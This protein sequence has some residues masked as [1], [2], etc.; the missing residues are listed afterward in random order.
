MPR[1]G[2]K[3]TDQEMRIAYLLCEG[4]TSRQIGMSLGISKRTAEVHV[5]N[6]MRGL[7]ATTRAQAVAMMFR[8]GWIS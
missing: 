6:L 7:G 1:A 3:P 5:M 2:V 8:K 4:L